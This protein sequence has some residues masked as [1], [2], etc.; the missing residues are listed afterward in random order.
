MTNLVLHN[1]PF[2]PGGKALFLDRDGVINVDTGYV[3][4]PETVTLVEGAG[5]LLAA[6]NSRKLPVIVVTNQS[7][8]SRGLADLA[9]LIAV[10][11]RIEALL[12]EKG[13]T[14]DA[15]L[16]CCAS[17]EGEGACGG[18]WR[19]PAPGMLIAAERLF[20]VDLANSIII[21]DKPSDIEAAAAAGLQSGILLD[22]RYAGD[23]DV[24]AAFSLKRSSSLTEVAQMLP[25]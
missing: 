17:S 5:Q 12:A 23:P 14:I 22:S 21:G 3:R 18:S 10:Q 7:A 1:R 4:D 13:A 24:P 19:K 11:S 9:T 15:V 20:G 8:L 6:A 16:M 25:Y 2:P